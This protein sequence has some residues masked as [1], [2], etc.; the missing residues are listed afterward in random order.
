[1]GKYMRLCLVTAYCAGLVSC[2]PVSSLAPGPLD[3][4]YVDVMH[5]AMVESAALSVAGSQRADNAVAAVARQR[6]SG[7]ESEDQGSIGQF[8]GT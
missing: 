7:A 1:M 4:R 8:D 6:R 3:G 5:E 2:M